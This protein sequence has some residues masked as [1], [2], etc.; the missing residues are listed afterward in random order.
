MNTETEINAMMLQNRSMQKK[1]E[2]KEKNHFQ[3]SINR[4][5]MFNSGLLKLRLQTV[6][7]A[8]NTSHTLVYEML[9]PRHRYRI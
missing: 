7:P 5:P 8:I 3:K 2:E 1:Y 4:F 9:A 6:S